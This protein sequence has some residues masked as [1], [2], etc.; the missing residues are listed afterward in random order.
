MN[1]NIALSMEIGSAY[2]LQVCLLQIPALVAWSAYSMVKL[3]KDQIPT[4][5]FT[6]IFP[7]WDLVTVILCVVLL[8]YMYGEGKS[9]YFK[10]CMLLGFLSVLERHLLITIHRVP[11]LSSA[12]SQS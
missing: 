6:L 2:A 10:V 4:H 12:I 3:S 7:Q 9:N 5:T 8:S 11:S 1:G